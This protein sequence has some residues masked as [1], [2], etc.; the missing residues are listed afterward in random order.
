MMP[1]PGNHDTPGVGSSPDTTH[2][3]ELFGPATYHAF[4]A[5]HA[6]FIALNSE[7]PNDF[8]MS[9]GEQ[10]AWVSAQLSNGD[11]AGADWLFAFWHI[12]PY[13]AGDRH[14][15]E[16]GSFRDLTA[17]FDGVVDWVFCGHEHLYQRTLPLRYNAQIANAYGRG[18]SDGVGYLIVPP[19]GVW[20]GTELIPHD[21]PKGYYRDRLAYPQ[22]APPSNT[23]PSEVGFVIVELEGK[24]IALTTWGMGTIETPLPAHVVDQASYTKP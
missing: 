11:I 24:T 13:N 6:A 22:V 17:L 1:A 8:A 16:Q 18:P 9:G 12:P 3:E 10:H 21:D 20:P 7:R 2:F 14:W 23:A 5:G 4:N 19:A 15:S